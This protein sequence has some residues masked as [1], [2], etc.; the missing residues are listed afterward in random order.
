[1][2]PLRLWQKEVEGTAIGMG[3]REKAEQV[4][5]T[6]LKLGVLTKLHIGNQVIR[7]CHHPFTKARSTRRIADQDH[8]VIANLRVLHILPGEAIGVLGTEK[9]CHIRTLS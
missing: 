4:V 2:R 7:R 5:T 3:I 6:E 9:R 8:F 1:M